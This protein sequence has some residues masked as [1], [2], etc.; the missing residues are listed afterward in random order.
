MVSREELLAAGLSEGQVDWR[1]QSGLLI[2]DYDG[3]YRLGHTAPNLESSYLAAVVACGEGSL[4]SGRAAAHL[5]G[6]VRARPPN[7]EVTTTTKRTP[8]GVIVHRKRF[9]HP[10][11]ATEYRG[12]PVT[13][14][15][16]TVADMAGHTTPGDLALLFHEARIRFSVTPEHVEAVLARSRVRGAAAL[17]RVMWGDERV[18]LS[19]LERGFIALL[20]TH[21][22]PLPG[23]NIPRG[24][25]WVDCWWPE[26]RLTVELDT[27]RYHGTRH[28]WEKDQRREREARKRGDHRRYVW[29]DVFETPEELLADLSPALAAP[30]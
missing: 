15:P 19:E 3:I 8:G 7:P 23:T 4:L 17:R 20:D 5:C 27:Y 10:R 24:A 28:A 25:H 22:L 2:P 12:I 29:G 21:H 16:R 30:S 9:I 26:F 1:V 6:L 11:D 18:L 13:T 14:V